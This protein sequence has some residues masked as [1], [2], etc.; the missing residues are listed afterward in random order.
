MIM[1]VILIT[2]HRA[3]PHKLIPF[4]FAEHDGTTGKNRIRPTKSQQ[5][6]AVTLFVS[7]ARWRYTAVTDQSPTAHQAHL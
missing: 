2:T 1:I 5:S 3:M 7:L 4:P 6:L